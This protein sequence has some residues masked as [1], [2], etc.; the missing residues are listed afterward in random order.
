[1]LIHRLTTINMYSTQ[2]TM[3]DFPYVQL[4]FSLELL[5]FL[6]YY[7]LLFLPAN[8]ILMKRLAKMDRKLTG[9]SSMIR[10]AIR[11]GMN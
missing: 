5:L 6:Y 11:E 4:S 3:G 1:M 9:I 7:F 8:K 10:K 2:E